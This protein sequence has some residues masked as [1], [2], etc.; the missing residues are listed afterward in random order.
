MFSLIFFV[1]FSHEAF[2]INIK[3]HESD[4]GKIIEAFHTPVMSPCTGRM[5][6][7]SSSTGEM[8][9]T[10]RAW[11]FS[12]LFSEYINSSCLFLFRN[13]HVL[14][15][16]FHVFCHVGEKSQYASLYFSGSGW[17]SERTKLMISHPVFSGV[18][19]TRSLVSI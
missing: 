10:L 17:L 14:H 4:Q 12:Y 11:G 6:T 13:I 15:F 9:L 5:L 1:M 7:L 3:G 19:V 8:L 18:R 16:L 2:L